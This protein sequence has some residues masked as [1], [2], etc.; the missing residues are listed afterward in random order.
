MYR[1]VEII[2]MKAI[3]FWGMCLLLCA[4]GNRCDGNAVGERSFMHYADSTRN[5][6]NFSKDPHVIW[7]KDRYLMY[8]SLGPTGDAGWAVGISESTNL[9]EWRP[10]GVIEPSAPYEANGFCAPC[11]LVRNDTVHL[12]YQTY[13]NGAKDAICHAWSSDGIHFERNAT[14]PVFSPQPADW[15]CGR[16]IDAEVVLVEGKYH[17]YYATRTPDYKK[18][19]IGVATAPAGT[20]FNTSAWSEIVQAP[21]LEPEYPWEETCT[22]GA[23]VVEQGGVYFTFYAGAYNNRPQQIGV[24]RSVDG[25]HWEKMS[26]K[27]FLPNGDPGSWNSCESGHPHLFKDRDGRTYL[28]YQGNNDN[29]K[30]WYLSQKEVVWQDGKPRLNE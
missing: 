11:A 18:Q 24:A 14:N 16:A 2:I 9:T 15:N 17:L 30:T 20:N 26:N 5:G 1:C 3:F 19:I 22:E 27:P 6:R 23:S 29:G 4:C 12:F 28:F 10:V 8:Y 7:Y 25:V 21:V 13:G